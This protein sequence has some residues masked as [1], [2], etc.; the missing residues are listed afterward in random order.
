MRTTLVFALSLILF[1]CNQ[2]QNT[3]EADLIQVL[4]DEHLII[5]ED[6]ELRDGTEVTFEKVMVESNDQE[7]FKANLIQ[8][9]LPDD[10]VKKT[11]HEIYLKQNEVG[12]WEV[13]DKKL[14]DIEC[15]RGK[16]DGM[17]I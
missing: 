15:R 1:G 8:D 3:N 6:G 13:V 4:V 14:V 7:W 9:N 12:E 10:S 11:E 2:S 5:L 17:C 16:V